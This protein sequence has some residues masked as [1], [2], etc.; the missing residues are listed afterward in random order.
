M[1]GSGT[2]RPHPDRMQVN[3]GLYTPM[4]R[5]TGECHRKRSIA[6]F[7]DDSTVCIR[8]ARR[9]PKVSA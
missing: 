2:S 5:C 9:A 7:K 1:N 6:Q 3:V 8:C 4:R